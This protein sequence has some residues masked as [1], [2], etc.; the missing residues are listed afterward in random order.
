MTPHENPTSV[1]KYRYRFRPTPE[2]LGVSDGV[3]NEEERGSHKDDAEKD[4]DDDDSE[5]DGDRSGGRVNGEILH[6]ETRSEG[7][8][9]NPP[10]GDEEVRDRLGVGTL[11][12]SIRQRL[13]HRQTRSAVD[14]HGDEAAGSESGTEGSGIRQL[15][16]GDDGVVEQKEC[17]SDPTQT[18]EST[19]PLGPIPSSSSASL[20]DSPTTKPNGSPNGSGTDLVEDDDQPSLNGALNAPGIYQNGL[21]EDT[22]S[23]SK[24]S[25]NALAPVTPITPSTPS[26]AFQTP[27]G[28]SAPPTSSRIVFPAPSFVSATTGLYTA[29]MRK[30]TTPVKGRDLRSQFDGADVNHTPSTSTSLLPPSAATTTVTVPPPET[31]RTP[32]RPIGTPTASKT[33]GVTPRQRYGTP[34]KRGRPY[35][36]HPLRGMLGGIESDDD[37]EDEVQR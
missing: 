5:D 4:D 13:L 15:S 17:Q 2:R 21:V 26:G 27:G 36:M 24:R 10:D 29:V 19:P 37:E 30:L 1:S 32:G 25:T 31:T 12:M 33:N 35:D 9:M 7:A 3:S 20:V 8:N 14:G 18:R 28:T 22:P 23:Y 11:A 6:G 34:R 16:P